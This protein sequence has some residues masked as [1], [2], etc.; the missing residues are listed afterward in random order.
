[1]V[2]LSEAPLQFHAVAD[3]ARDGAPGQQAGMLE[4]HGAID[5]RSV[6]PFLYQRC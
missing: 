3:I 5:T 1:M 2:F 4:D 6:D